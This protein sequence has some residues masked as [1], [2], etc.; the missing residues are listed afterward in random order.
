[1]ACVLWDIRPNSINIC[2]AVQSLNHVCLFAMLWRFC[3]PPLSPG[4]CSDSCPSWPTRVQ[5]QQVTR[6]GAQCFHIKQSD[7]HISGIFPS[8]LE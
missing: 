1:M 2:V 6:P 7:P 5:S 3:S 8:S 4:V